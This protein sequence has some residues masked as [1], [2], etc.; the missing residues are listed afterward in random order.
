M[1][2]KVDSASRGPQMEANFG[3][4]YNDWGKPVWPEKLKIKMC[5]TTTTTSI[6]GFD[7][8]LLPKI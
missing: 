8:I 6:S 3:I 2:R 7:R 4:S 1:F 5:A